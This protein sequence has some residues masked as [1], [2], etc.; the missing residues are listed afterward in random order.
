[1]EDIPVEIPELPS[2]QAIDRLVSLLEPYRRITQPTFYG[3][4]N[5]PD[6]GSLLVGNHTIYGFLDLPFMM[7]RSGRAAGSSPAVRATTPT[8]RS[9]SGG[10][11]SARAGWSAA[12]ATMSAP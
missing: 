11:F 4:G 2:E 7:A 9:R 6:G 10:T 3:M 5:L 1:M 12:P 8:T